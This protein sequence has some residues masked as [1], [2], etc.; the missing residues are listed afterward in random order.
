MPQLGIVQPRHS[1][2]S[3]AHFRGLNMIVIFQSVDNP[4]CASSRLPS[5]IPLP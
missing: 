1:L 5:E 4:C 2:F 3:C